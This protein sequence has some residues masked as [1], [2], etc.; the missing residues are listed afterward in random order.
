M[1]GQSAFSLCPVCLERIPAIHVTEGDTVYLAKECGKHGSF[2]TAIWKGA[3][4]LAAWCLNSEKSEE[5]PA[6]P[7]SC[8]LCD[9]HL[10]KTCCAILNVTERCNLRCNYCFEGELS[11]HEPTLD[12]IKSSLCDMASKGI[13]FVHL[14]GGEPTVRDDIPEIAAYAV[15]LGFE[16]IQSNTNGLRLADDESYAGKLADAGISAIFLQFDGTSDKVFLALRGRP[17]FSKKCR[18]IENCGKAFLGVVLVP[19]IVP[20][21]N[22]KEIGS[23][24]RFGTE[25]I[26]FV[27]GIHFQPVTY[28]GRF[29]S[30][31]ENLSRITL[32][33]IL[34]ALE[35]QTDGRV[36]AEQFSPRACDHPM[37]GFH[38]EFV[39]GHDGLKPLSRTRSRKDAATQGFYKRCG[40]REKEPEFR[41]LPLD[42]ESQRLFRC[43]F[44]ARHFLEKRTD[45]RILNQR[46]GI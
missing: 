12:Y 16:Y 38:G 11:G 6:C 40:S 4:N 14:S 35:E 1:A 37:C 24:V 42:A 15:S 45:E 44:I 19:T 20:H 31:Q 36:R 21:L 22:G 7:E 46:Y 27:K 30:A 2:R 10:R 8:G 23:I 39:Y 17:L 25:H 43:R 28:V 33:E 34:S 3:T 32:P 5:N 26:P 13:T 29:P 41:T 9:S 18:A